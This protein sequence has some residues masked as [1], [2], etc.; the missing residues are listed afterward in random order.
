MK[1]YMFRICL[2]RILLFQ[3]KRNGHKL[4]FVNSE[5]LKKHAEFFQKFS[6]CFFIF[7]QIKIILKQQSALR[8]FFQ[9]AGGLFEF[10]CRCFCKGKAV[11]SFAACA[12]ILVIFLKNIN[13]DCSFCSDDFYGSRF[14]IRK[15]FCII[16]PAGSCA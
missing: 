12:Y 14:F 8:L 3:T 1:I 4:K 11:R 15:A 6:A 10:C 2:C 7:L 9:F 13:S 5:H 16:F